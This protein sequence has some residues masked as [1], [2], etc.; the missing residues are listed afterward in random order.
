G[1]VGEILVEHG[2][3]V[4]KGDPVVRLDSPELRKQLAEKQA[5]LGE[6]QSQVSRLT[7][8]VNKA[9][10]DERFQLL[11]Q[12]DEAEIKAK[13]AREQIDIIQEQL[14]SMEITAPLD[15]IVTTWEVRKKLAGLPVEIGKD[16]VEIASTDGEWVLEVDV[17]DDDMEPILEARAKLQ[18]EIKA[19]KRKPEAR[20][21]AHFVTAADPEHRYPGHVVRI[22]SKA[23]TV[24]GK[25]QVKVTVGFTDAVRDD[26]LK[27]NNI[28]S[29]R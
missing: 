29:L 27:R 23:E 10:S 6:A 12:L 14:D 18:T 3:R 1:K 24:E 15:G 13:G 25:H 19:G 28:T 21:P 22:A 9:R 5:E 4:H 20:P 2:D 11:A 17:P 7:R 16:L 8:Q 26:F